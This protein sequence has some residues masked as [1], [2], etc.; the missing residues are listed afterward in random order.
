MLSSLDTEKLEF[1][2]LGK[3]EKVQMQLLSIFIYS[4]VMNFPAACFTPKF[5]LALHH[6]FMYSKGERYFFPAV[7]VA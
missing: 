3:W 7:V 6:C 2:G 1:L 5:L 4:H